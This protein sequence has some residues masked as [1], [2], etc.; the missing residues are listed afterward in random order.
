MCP[1][2]RLALA[3]CICA[4]KTKASANSALHL[5]TNANRE[6]TV[7]VGLESKRRSGKT[8]SVVRGLVLGNDDLHALAKRLRTACGC[9]GTSKDGA[10]E[11]Q[12]DH[13]A[14]LLELL[15]AQGIAAKRTDQG[16]P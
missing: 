11:L 3:A 14:R 2:C 16:N 12:G 9:G 15:S 13:C 6:L 1:D 10:I 5:A 8:V 4:T 7:R